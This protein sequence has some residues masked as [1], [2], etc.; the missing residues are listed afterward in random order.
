MPPLPAEDIAIDL[1]LP[2]IP[3]QGTKRVTVKRPAEVPSILMAYKVPSLKTSMESNGTIDAWVPYALDVLAEVMNGGSSARFNARLVRGQEVAASMYAEYSMTD[4]LETLYI[5]GGTPAQDKTVPELEAA[6]NKER[7]DLQTT[8][9]EEAELRRVKAQVVSN[10]VYQRDSAFY[11]GMI[12][13]TLETVGLNWEL[14]NVY[15][16]RIQAITAEQVRE[17]ARRYLVED[18]LTV[19]ELVPQAIENSRPA[20]R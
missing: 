20:G 19:A 2:E 16:E 17:V 4:R 10:E 18:G 7:S 6:I 15:V 11:Q 13:G 8:L 3:Q 9:V 14:S 12:I 1:P 5:I